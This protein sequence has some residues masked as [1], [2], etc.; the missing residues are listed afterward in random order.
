VG[1]TLVYDLLFDVCGTLSPNFQVIVLD[2]KNLVDHQQFQ[3]SIVDGVIWTADHGLV[4]NSWFAD[5]NN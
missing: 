5:S 4:P 1:L 3:N 2:H